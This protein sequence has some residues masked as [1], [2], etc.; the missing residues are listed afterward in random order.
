[1]KKK[2]CICGRSNKKWITDMF[3][4]KINC[5]AKPYYCNTCYGK[6]E[7]KIRCPRHFLKSHREDL[8]R[9]KKVRFE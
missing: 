6:H 1:M 2:C 3:C 7:D 4:L 5:L 9:H 8:A